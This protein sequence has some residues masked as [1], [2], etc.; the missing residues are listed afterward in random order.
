MGKKRK[1]KI[2]SELKAN[3]PLLIF[4]NAMSYYLAAIL[5]DKHAEIGDFRIFPT[6]TLQALSLELFIKCLHKTRRRTFKFK[7]DITD[8]L[9]G[10]S[11]SD[12]KKIEAYLQ[13]GLSQHPQFEGLKAL[14]IQFD[15]DSIAK[16]SADM[17]L[18]ARYWHELV[19][20]ARDDKGFAGNFGLLTLC[21]AIRDLLFEINPDWRSKINNFRVIMPQGAPPTSQAR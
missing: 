13:K 8:L 6:Q 2:K 3:A 14:G 1:R 19:L 5:L 16:R 20:P 12:R 18:R 10:I 4:A 17:F 9:A 11:R 15:I 7:H 21:E